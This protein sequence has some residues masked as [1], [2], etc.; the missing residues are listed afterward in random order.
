MGEQYD[1]ADSVVDDRHPTVLLA[2]S[3][4]MRFPEAVRREAG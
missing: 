4:C 1:D 3:E 2:A